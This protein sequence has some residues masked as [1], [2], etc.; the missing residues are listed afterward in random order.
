MIQNCIQHICLG[1]HTYILDLVQLGINRFQLVVQF[2]TEFAL[3][4]QV[5]LE[6]S[7]I[8]YK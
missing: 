1:M 8:I 5:D 7:Y 4:L 6:Q 3:S 2:E